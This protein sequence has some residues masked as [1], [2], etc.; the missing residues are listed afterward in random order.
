MNSVKMARAG[1]GIYV[2]EVFHCVT[3][4]DETNKFVMF[5]PGQRVKFVK[6][7]GSEVAFEINGIQHR[8]PA[9]HFITTD[10][11]KELVKVFGPEVKK[12]EP[13]VDDKYSRLLIWVGILVPLIVISGVIWMC[14][15]MMYGLTY[16][17]PVP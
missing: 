6:H 16:H 11:W 1:D 4:G 5:F 10:A 15:G 9:G 7:Y 17:P 14:A 13:P 12:P 3:P 2:V 8:A